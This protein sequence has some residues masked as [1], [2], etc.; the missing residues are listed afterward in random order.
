ML[1]HLKTKELVGH[2][3]KDTGRQELGAKEMMKVGEYG[4]E[5]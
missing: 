2:Q 4:D 1:R 3:K 5:Q